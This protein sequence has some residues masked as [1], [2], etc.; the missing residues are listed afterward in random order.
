MRLLSY[1]IHKGIGGRDRRYRLER[2]IEVIEQE[3]PDLVCLQEVDH[4]VRRSRFHDQPRLLAD[5][6]HAVAHLHQ[7]NVRLKSGGYGNLILSRWPL[8][9]KHQISLRLGRK[10]PRGAQMVVGRHA[11]GA[12][13]P[14]PLAPGPGRTGAALAGE[15]FARRIRCFS[16]RPSCPR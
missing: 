8:A 2:V 11:R 9:G 7:T 3:N 12:A 1:N 5:Y 4:N 10:R 14:G 13:A 6:F 16:S 15:P